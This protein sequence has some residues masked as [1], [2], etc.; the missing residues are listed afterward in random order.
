MCTVASSTSV[1]PRPNAPT[2]GLA[3]LCGQASFISQNCPSP[4]ELKT[5]IV[6]GKSNHRSHPLA[7]ATGWSR[8]RPDRGP[9]AAGAKW[10]ATAPLSNSAPT[11]RSTTT[12]YGPRSRVKPAM[13]NS[14]PYRPT[15][16]LDL[17]LPQRNNMFCRGLS[18]AAMTC[19]LANVDNRGRITTTANRA[20]LR[21]AYAQ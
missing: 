1:R 6:T 13:C 20:S 15:G 7:A 11:S 3:T 9:T 4:L 2:T 8:S 19:E 10:V 5:P 14:R 21:G 16:Q 18:L 12:C 17:V